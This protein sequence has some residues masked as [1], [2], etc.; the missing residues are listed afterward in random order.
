MIAIGS[1][2]ID[3][4]KIVGLN[5]QKGRIQGERNKITKWR[6]IQSSKLK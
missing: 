4:N 3:M 6:I 2:R 1:G 5:K